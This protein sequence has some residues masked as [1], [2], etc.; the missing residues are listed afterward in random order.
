MLTTILYGIALAIVIIYSVQG[1]LVGIYGKT[2]HFLKSALGEVGHRYFHIVVGV[3]AL[4][5]LFAHIPLPGMQRKVYVV[6]GFEVQEVCKK[7]NGDVCKKD[8]PDCKCVKTGCMKKDGSG[9]AVECKYPEDADVEGCKECKPEG[10]E[11]D[12]STETQPVSEQAAP[13]E[14]A[15]VEGSGLEGAP[16]TA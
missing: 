1:G 9:N 4:I 11:G 13:T 2:A 10:F 15:P 16:W 14:P 5:V 3:A 12:V 7:A 8:E 6:D